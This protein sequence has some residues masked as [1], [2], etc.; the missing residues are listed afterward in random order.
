MEAKSTEYFTA[1]HGMHVRKEANVVE[2]NYVQ[3]R[4]FRGNLELGF[5][6]SDENVFPQNKVWCNA[7][8]MMEILIS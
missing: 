4:S 5:F 8:N 1:L 3:V 6:V 2:W 7:P